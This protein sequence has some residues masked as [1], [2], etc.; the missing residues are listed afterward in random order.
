MPGRTRIRGFD[1]EVQFVASRGYAVLRPS[2]RGGRGYDWMSPNEDRYEFLK[3]HRDLT[4]AIKATMA[5]PRGR[6]GDSLLA[7]L[8]SD[9]PSE[10]VPVNKETPPARD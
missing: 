2:Y 6:R 1:G 8:F 3:M 10:P 4:D 7:K 9:H 5:R